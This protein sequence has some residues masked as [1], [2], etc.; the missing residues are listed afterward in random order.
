VTLDLGL[1]LE[2]ED[3]RLAPFFVLRGAAPPAPAPTFVV[4]GALPTARLLADGSA[5][6]FRARALVCTPTHRARLEDAGLLPPDL[7]VFEGSR[8]QLATL[9][10]FDFHRGVLACAD[11]PEV[12]RG[13]PGGALSPPAL[14]ALRARP[15]LTVVVASGLA[16][17]RNL[18]AVIRNAA[19]FDVDLVVIDAKGADPLSRLAIR[20]SVGNVFRVP[21]IRSADLDA[22][23]KELRTEL[24]ATVIASTPSASTELRAYAR[25]RRV[26]LMVGNEGQGLSAS[27]LEHA[28]QRLRIAVA[29][30]SDSVNVA[31]ATAILLHALSV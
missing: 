27:Q 10:G 4:E 3:P 25:P 17:P 22:S 7:P 21:M 11:V 14:D 16:D 2:S 28:D 6:G 18:G 31:A 12:L 9:A 5:R 26:L 29:P 23:I 24:P 15:R 1:A 20:A 13:G 30:G 8:A 19:A